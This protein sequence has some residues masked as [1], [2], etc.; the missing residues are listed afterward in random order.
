MQKKLSAELASELRSLL[1]LPVDATEDD[2][3]AATEVGMEHAIKQLLTKEPEPMH[4]VRRKLA[5]MWGFPDNLTDDEINAKLNGILDEAK[6][7][8][9]KEMH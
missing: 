2:I 7:S 5:R 4:V 6:A 3:R 1:N 9:R 8:M